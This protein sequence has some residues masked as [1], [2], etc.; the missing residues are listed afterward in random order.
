M[1]TSV[2]NIHSVFLPTHCAQWVGKK[3]LWILATLV[4][5]ICYFYTGELHPGEVTVTSLW[6]LKSIQTLSFTCIGVVTPA[7]LSEICDYGELRSGKVQSGSYFAVQ[8]CT[9]K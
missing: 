7:I 6:V 1:E 8:A 4:S 5:M 3:T 2:A 9:A